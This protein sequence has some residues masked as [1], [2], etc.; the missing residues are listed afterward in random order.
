APCNNRLSALTELR[1]AALLQALRAGPGVWPAE[2]ALHAATRGGA[3][4]LGLDDVGSIRPGM[5]ADLVLFDLDVPELD[6][7][8]DPVAKLVYSADERHIRQ[9]WLGGER[10]V[11]DGALTAVDPRAVAATARQQRAAVLQR[12]GLR[13]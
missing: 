12:A 1:E 4:A 8:G 6:P 9:V 11:D 5:R 10:V 2:Q 13:A 7:G 3:E